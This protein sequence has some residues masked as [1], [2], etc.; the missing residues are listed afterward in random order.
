VN[1]A[2]GTGLYDSHH[3]NLLEN[4]KLFNLTII[5]TTN[6]KNTVFLLLINIGKLKKDLDLHNEKN[7]E[8]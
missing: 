5:L 6:Q 3:K 1:K 8:G 7:C 2:S 4:Q